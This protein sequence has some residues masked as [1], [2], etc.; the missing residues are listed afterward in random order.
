MICC[1]LFAP[2]AVCQEYGNNSASLVEA[3]ITFITQS[4]AFE[5]QQ[6][7]LKV[8]VD[9]GPRLPRQCLLDT[10]SHH[11]ITSDHSLQHKIFS[12]LLLLET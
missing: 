11:A 3:T 6:L 8:L 12:Y 5:T 2:E 10:L 4:L 9:L 7:L 1:F